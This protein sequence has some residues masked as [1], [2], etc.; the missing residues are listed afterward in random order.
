MPVAAG[1]KGEVAAVP[2]ALRTLFSCDL[3]TDFHV[4]Q[5]EV[6]HV[7]P[8]LECALACRCHVWLW[9]TRTDETEQLAG[10]TVPPV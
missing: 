7:L 3:E 2:V 1:G 8:D 10:T 4:L 6:S 5:N 9:A